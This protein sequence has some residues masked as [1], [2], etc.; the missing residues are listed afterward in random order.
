MVILVCKAEAQ[1][2]AEC[3]KLNWN[4]G[5]AIS[6]PKFYK[7]DSFLNLLGSFFYYTNCH[8]IDSQIVL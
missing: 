6:E 1:K 2:I 4:L 3:R 8:I 7:I 5:M